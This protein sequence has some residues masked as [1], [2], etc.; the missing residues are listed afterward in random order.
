[1]WAEPVWGEQFVLTCT[2]S[3]SNYGFTFDAGRTRAEDLAPSALD[4]Y[5]SHDDD[6]GEHEA[7]G[8]GDGI[9]A[10]DLLEVS[11][12]ERAEQGEPDPAFAAHQAGSADDAGGDGIE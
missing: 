4:Q 3:P 1:M 9:D 10:K 12:D 5:S 6:A 2:R 7:L 11:D 8:L